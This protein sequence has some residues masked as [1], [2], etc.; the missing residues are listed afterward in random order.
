MWKEIGRFTVEQQ[1]QQSESLLFPVATHRIKIT[2]VNYA[3][4][5]L[6]YV[7][8]GWCNL[9]DL[10]GARLSRHEITAGAQIIPIRT[11]PDLFRVQYSPAKWLYNAQLI[12]H[13]DDKPRTPPVVCLANA[14]SDDEDDWV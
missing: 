7:K 5:Q 10:D 4:E 1:G 3:I 14:V 9:L 11:W 6:G 12:I 2:A 13:A 8:F